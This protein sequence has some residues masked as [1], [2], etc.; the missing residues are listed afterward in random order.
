ML[1]TN[2]DLHCLVKQRYTLQE[3]QLQEKYN[4]RLSHKVSVA[5]G[6]NWRFWFVFTLLP[7]S[8]CKRRPTDP[9]NVH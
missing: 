8:L 6:D 5:N 7:L 3:S 1:P 9:L 4:G 2:H